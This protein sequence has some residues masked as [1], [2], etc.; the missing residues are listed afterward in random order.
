MCA[1]LD[2]KV[3]YLPISKASQGFYKQRLSNFNFTFYSIPS[4]EYDCYVWN[5]AQSRRGSSEMSSNVAKALKFYD[6]QGVKKAY[7][8]ADGCGGQNKNS[9]FPAMML[10]V[11]LHSK[12]LKQ[13]SLR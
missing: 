1:N 2:L 12:N 8:F 11:V 10:Y 7:L 3:I 13:V 4:K 5:E 6:E 9:I